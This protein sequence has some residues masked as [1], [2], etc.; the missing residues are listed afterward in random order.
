MARNQLPSVKYLV[1][2]ILENRS[3]D[4]MLGFLYAVAGNVS[5]TGQPFEGLVG[6]ESNTDA[7]GNTVTVYQ[8]DHAA[9]CTYFMPGADPG[10]D[11]RISMNNCS[12]VASPRFCRVFLARRRRACPAGECLRG[13][14]RPGSALII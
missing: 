5:P 4:H 2:L 11:T 14:L 6:S 12:A 8:I 7:S 9:P 10:E 13:S 1:Q 3:F